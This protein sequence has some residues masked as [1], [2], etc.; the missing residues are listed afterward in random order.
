[1]RRDYDVL[2]GLV[3]SEP[4]RRLCHELN[5]LPDAER[6]AYV[7][8]VFLCREE[9]AKRGVEVPEGVLIQRSS[10]GDRRPTLF[11]VKKY[12]PTKFHS[13][14]E[15]VNLTFDASYSDEEVSRDPSICWRNPLRPDYQAELMA[16]GVGRQRLSDRMA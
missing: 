16:Q 12:L 3:V 1:M 9:L 10:F 4:F 14:W 13:A 7:R 11:C 15:N 5:G 8:N 6:E 2:I